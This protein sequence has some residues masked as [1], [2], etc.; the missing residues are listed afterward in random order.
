MIY[1][2]L[3]YHFHDSLLIDCQKEK[4]NRFSLT[5]QLYELFYP[6]KDSVKL[7]LS[8][9]FNTEKTTKWFEQLKAEQK[10]DQQTYFRVDTIN[11]DTKKI[12]KD[13]DLYLFVAVDGAAPITIHCKKIRIE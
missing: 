5:L 2:E 11:Y 1:K 10:E 9:V 8:G 13:L 7:T 4:E 12:S 6:S 3:P